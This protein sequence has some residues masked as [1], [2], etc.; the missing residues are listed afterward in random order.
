MKEF[1]LGNVSVIVALCAGVL[2]VI[3]A[4]FLYGKLSPNIVLRVSPCWSEDDGIVKIS[5]SVENQGLIRIG[6]GDIFFHFESIKIGEDFVVGDEWIT[7]EK[8]DAIMSSTTYIN[9]KE[10]ISIDRMYRIPFGHYIHAGLQVN[11][12]Y[13]WFISILGRQARSTRQTRTYYFARRLAA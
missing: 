10:N 12:R 7:F 5:I 4:T 3:T 1:V 9:P 6:L 2:A 13:P 8:S 11:L